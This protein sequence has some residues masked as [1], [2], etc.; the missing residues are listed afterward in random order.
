MVNFTPQIWPRNLVKMMIAHS[1]EGYCARRLKINMNCRSLS[2]EGCA[3]KRAT[4]KYY[5][6]MHTAACNILNG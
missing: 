5:L 4:R 2:L 1:S 6:F 3:N